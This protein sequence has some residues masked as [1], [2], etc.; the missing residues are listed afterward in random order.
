MRLSHL[1]GGHST[2]VDLPRLS[3]RLLPLSVIGPLRFVR[4]FPRQKGP[5]GGFHHA[6]DVGVRVLELSQ[7]IGKICWARNGELPRW[8]GWRVKLP[9]NVIALYF[10][11]FDFHFSSGRLF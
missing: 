8:V 11:F 7:A 1:S 9:V 10:K 5:I 4:R 2:Q 6:V 3:G